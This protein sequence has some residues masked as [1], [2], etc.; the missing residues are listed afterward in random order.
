[1]AVELES[2]FRLLGL[3][4]GLLVL[5]LGFWIVVD[6]EGEGEGMG[7]MVVVEEWV[8][9]VRDLAGRVGGGWGVEG[10][11]SVSESSSQAM[12]SVGVRAAPGGVC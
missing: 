11:E 10:W 6:E 4:L 9:W 1:M 3:R 7:W 5:G 12:F 2:R 8:C